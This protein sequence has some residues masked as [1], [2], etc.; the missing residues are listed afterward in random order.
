MGGRKQGQGLRPWTPTQARLWRGPGAE[1]PGLACLNPSKLQHIPHGIQPRRF[2]LQPESGA[3]GTGGKDAA[4]ES[5]V[6]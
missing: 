1:P 4:V 6:G 2:G 5:V 3:D